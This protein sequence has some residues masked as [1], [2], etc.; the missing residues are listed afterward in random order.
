MELIH[1]VRQLRAHGIPC[2]FTID[3]G[4]HV[5]V[6]CLPDV[7]EK[8]QDHF[9]THPAVVDILMAS[10]GAGAELI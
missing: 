1:E 7:A 2:F 4:P 10:P 8:L 3:A 5:K 9:A 6:F